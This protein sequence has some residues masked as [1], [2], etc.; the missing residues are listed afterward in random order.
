MQKLRAKLLPSHR[1]YQ[2]NS[3]GSISLTTTVHVSGIHTVCNTVT[4]NGTYNVII[5]N[6]C[7][8]YYHF[9]ECFVPNEPH[10]RLLEIISRGDH[11]LWP[12][13]YYDKI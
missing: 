11:I 13:L 1:R 7:V 12:K 10:A 2:N 4:H 5:R 8:L 3:C 6:I 9:Y